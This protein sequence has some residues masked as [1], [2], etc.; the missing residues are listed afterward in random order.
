MSTVASLFSLKSLRAAL[1]HPEHGVKTTHFWGPVANWGIVGAAVIDATSQGPEVISLPLTS[2]MCVYSALF[3]GFAW[4][5]QPRNYLLL[6]CH[7]FNE[8]VQLYQLRRGYKY[9]TQQRRNG[10]KP[11]DRFSASGFAA[12]V[13]A[14][15]YSLHKLLTINRP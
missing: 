3:M 2:S 15:N 11:Q 1:T 7:A 13:L 14:G 4:S 8:C 9:Q 12:F 5:V 10:E 6:S